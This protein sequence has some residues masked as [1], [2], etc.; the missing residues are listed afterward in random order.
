MILESQNL[1]LQVSSTLS[2]AGLCTTLNGN[3]IE[4]TFNDNSERIKRFKELL[5]S[6]QNRP[7]QPMVIS[8]SG[9]IHHKNIWLNVRDVTS[10][11]EAKGIMS[12]AINDWKDSVSVR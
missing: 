1:N 5:G 10:K 6:H 7:F 11:D 3:S 2:D 4:E 8:G 12:V 9:N